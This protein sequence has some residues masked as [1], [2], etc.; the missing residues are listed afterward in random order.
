MA[1]STSYSHLIQQQRDMAARV[2]TTDSFSPLKL[3]A[4]A[5]VGFEQ[6]GAV[7][8][9]AIAVLSFPQLE[10][11]DCAIAR[12]P[13][14]IP[15]IPG[16]LSFREVPVLLEA[17]SMLNTA[18]DI[19]LVDGQGLAHPRR[20]GVACHLGLETDLPTVGVAKSR[21]CGQH[22]DVPET[23]GGWVPLLDKAECIGAVVRTRTRVKPLY[24]SSGHKISLSSAVSLVLDCTT[25]Y[26][27][28][29][30][31]RW[32]DG[33]ASGH[34]QAPFYSLMPAHA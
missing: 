30:T 14:P 24:I 32:A 33:L 31:T 11:V 26:R 18:P 1:A 3:V 27:L 7:T 29:E 28:P 10:L 12:L 19:V 8:R 22:E 5:D 6:N 15:Y 17:L 20:C 13:T 9:G 25:K 23:K 16:L 21:L 34:R 4:G 2:I